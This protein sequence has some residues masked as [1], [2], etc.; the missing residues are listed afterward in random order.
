MLDLF[1]QLSGLTLTAMLLLGLIVGSFLNVV[2]HRLPAMLD[3]GWKLQCRELLQLDPVPADVPGLLSPRSRC[4]QCGTTIRAIDNIPVLSYVFLRGRC[5]HCGIRISARYP[6]VEVLTAG[7]S[8]FVLWHFDISTQAAAG[9]M[10]T[11]ILIPL[12]FIDVDH[13][14]LPDSITLPGLWLG[15]I[16]NIFGTFTDL[17][18]AVIGAAAGYVALWLLFQGFR[19]LTGKEGMG[20]GDFKLFAMFGAWLGWQALPLIIILAA[21]AGAVIGITLIITKGHDRSIPIPFGPYLCIAGWIAMI[22]GDEITRAY[23]RTAGIY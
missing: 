22:W 9:V 7:M 2:I 11:W 23:L 10:L 5:H 15:L 19:L 20:Y 13:Q 16:V 17:Q 18:S 6:V 21:C 12:A 3:Y 4:P 1:A 8:V 14:L